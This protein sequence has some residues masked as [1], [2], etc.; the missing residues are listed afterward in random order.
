MQED[1]GVGQQCANKTDMQQHQNKVAFAL[2]SFQLM[3]PP[4]PLKHN[5]VAMQEPEHTGYTLTQA[6][7]AQQNV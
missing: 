4:A 6:W 1:C 2:L 3:N 7:F 5:L